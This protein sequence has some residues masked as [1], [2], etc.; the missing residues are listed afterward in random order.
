MDYETIICHH[1][2]LHFVV[3]PSS[4]TGSHSPFATCMSSHHRHQLT[5]SVC[6]CIY[7]YLEREIQQH[8]SSSSCACCGGQVGSVLVTAAV[9]TTMLPQRGA[10]QQKCKKS[11]GGKYFLHPWFH[12][13]K[14]LCNLCYLSG[15]VQQLLPAAGIGSAGTVEN[16]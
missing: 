15:G 5:R 16:L 12:G 13:K 11:G 8:S 7:T 2:A 9:S 4:A 3:E 10:R 1:R 14:F 6:M